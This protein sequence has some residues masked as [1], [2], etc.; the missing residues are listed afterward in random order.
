MR[1]HHHVQHVQQATLVAWLKRQAEQ[2]YG[3]G[4]V[5]RDV[6]ICSCSDGQYYRAT[7][8]SYSKHNG[9]HK[10]QYGD[11]HVEELHLPVELLSFEEQQPVAQPCDALSDEEMAAPPDRLPGPTHGGAMMH[12]HFEVGMV[13]VDCA[14]FDE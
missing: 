1:Y 7:I 5:G 10:V 9:K 8:I 11:R 6:W 13:Q 4:V 12:P 2:R 14:T 3:E